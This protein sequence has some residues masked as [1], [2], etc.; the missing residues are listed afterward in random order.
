VKKKA[1]I[2]KLI[3]PYCTVPDHDDDRIVSHVNRCP[4]KSVR[5]RN[6]SK[7]SKENKRSNDE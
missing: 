6:S 1:R 2:I 3:T 7:N 4:N 5:K